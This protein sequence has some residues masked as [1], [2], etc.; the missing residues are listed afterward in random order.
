MLFQ[1]RAEIRQAPISR[2]KELDFYLYG[3]IAGRSKTDA[4]AYSQIMGSLMPG[5]LDEDATSP[6]LR[7]C[8]AL[9][10]DFV[11]WR[12]SREGNPQQLFSCWYSER[13][14]PIN[15]AIAVFSNS[16]MP[17]SSEPKPDYAA[18]YAAGYDTKKMAALFSALEEAAPS[19]LA[20]LVPRI[21][22]AIVPVDETRAAFA[23][24]S[25]KTLG[26][27]VSAWIPL[28]MPPLKALKAGPA[29]AEL[30]KPALNSIAKN[31]ARAAASLVART[32]G[33]NSSVKLSQHEFRSITQKIMRG[34]MGKV[35]SNEKIL[36]G[37]RAFTP[38]FLR[39][40]EAETIAQLSRQSLLKKQWLSS[41]EYC[42]HLAKQF[43]RLLGKGGVAPKTLVN[44]NSCHEEV[45]QVG[46]IAKAIKDGLRSVSTEKFT[47]MLGSI[48]GVT[49]SAYR[50]GSHQ[51]LV[52]SF[53]KFN[54]PLKF[55]LAEKVDP[56]SAE[57]VAALLYLM[58]HSPKWI[59]EKL[60]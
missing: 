52:F 27:L 16:A 59:A 15:S 37:E 23:A 25:P 18:L 26:G 11:K 51:T 20:K 39:I 12:G 55:I 54:Y 60:L 9:F 7:A 21:V 1:V 53:K 36:F 14:E 50:P 8:F 31:I 6:M 38:S 13:Y 41:T 22:K 4:Y 28:L 3:M 49:A 46:E 5:G 30:S 32:I 43:R 48:P 19:K 17:K 42:L 35:S 44:S 57:D 24:R 47:R 58:G 34:V 33:E 29:V 45:K 56:S 10:S 2:L 40:C